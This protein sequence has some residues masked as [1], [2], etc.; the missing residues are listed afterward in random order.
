M[1]FI[2]I[3]THSE[4]MNP[5]YTEINK[6]SRV[7]KLTVKFGAMNAG[8]SDMLIKTAF[9]YAE[10]DLKVVTMMPDFAAREKGMI[11]SRPG[12]AWPIDI[13]VHIHDLLDP[14]SE[15]NTNVRH[16][17]HEHMGKSAVHCVLVDEA[18]FFAEEQI[19]QLEEIAKI[20]NISVI[21]HCLRSDVQRKLFQ[22]SK[23]LFELADSF[24]KMPTMC[25]CGSQA[26]YN[27]RF[28]NGTFHVGE[29]IVMMDNDTTK[30]RYQS[31]CA[32]C[33]IGHLSDPGATTK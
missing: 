33:Y 4:Q 1:F 14:D 6:G 23:R 3:F 31:M 13:A 18:Q 19:E 25:T 21:A 9:N 32:R 11:T 30:V 12:G 8:K 27:G 7:S 28:V 5:R 20:D 15:P 26:E 2:V 17:L 10:Q 29:P 22:G 16:A 24:E